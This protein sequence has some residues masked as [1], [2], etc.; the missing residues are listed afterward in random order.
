VGKD[1]NHGTIVRAFEQAGATVV[2][3]H[4]LGKGVPDLLVGYA[5]R[6]QL[7]EIKLPLRKASAAGAIQHPKTRL[8]NRQVGW[9]NNW[10]G[11]RPRIIRTPEEAE[12]LLDEMADSHRQGVAAA[13]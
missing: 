1:A 11:T 9:H 6:D 10:R 7:V 13:N 2:S 5:D 3:L 12:N 4:T 8:N